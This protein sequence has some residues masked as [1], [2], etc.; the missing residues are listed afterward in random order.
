LRISVVFRRADR[1]WI[2]LEN[3]SIYKNG[4]K[5]TLSADIWQP[6]PQ[7]SIPDDLAAAI[8]G[9][10]PQPPTPLK[11]P[12]DCKACDCCGEVGHEPGDCPAAV[13]FLDGAD[14]S[15]DEEA[16]LSSIHSADSPPYR[17]LKQ[18]RQMGVDAA[19][20][21]PEVPPEPHVAAGPSQPADAAMEAIFFTL[22]RLMLNS[23]FTHFTLISTHVDS[24]V[25]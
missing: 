23:F 15:S 22:L 7:P 14:D 13:E 18:S 16:D 24:C 1:D 19:A 10:S 11:A 8:G 6:L 9:G 3:H 4:R 2:D 21:K 25:L 17:R 20:A 12:D 5:V